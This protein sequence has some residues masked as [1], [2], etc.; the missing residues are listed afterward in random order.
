MTQPVEFP[1]LPARLG[2]L[3]DLAYNLWWSWQPDARN[4]FRDLR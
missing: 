1:H 4:L 2:G 3:K